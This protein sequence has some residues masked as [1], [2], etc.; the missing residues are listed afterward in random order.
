MTIEIVSGSPRATS[1]T[2]RIA[3]Y[4]QQ[5]IQQHYKENTIGVIDVREWKL[6]FLET[7]FNSVENTPDQYKPLT[8]RMFAADAFIIVTPEYNGSYTSEI[9]NLFDH[10]P[11]QSRKAFGIC[12]ASTGVL[13]G[14][15]CTQPL[16]LLVPALFGIASPS[17][18]IVPNI[19]KKFNA[20]NELTDPS[21]EKQIH[22]FVTEFLWLGN[23]LML[24]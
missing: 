15:R 5:Y 13:G 19:D 22:Q 16:L 1:I 12:T 10:F 8:Q 2:V 23:N 20:N 18:L 21:F 6:G 17:L 4:L 7:V 3:K 9:K 24:K 14:A 11:K